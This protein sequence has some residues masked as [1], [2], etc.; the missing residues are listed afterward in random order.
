MKR[1][2]GKVSDDELI[3]LVKKCRLPDTTIAGIMGYSTGTIATRRRALLG[4]KTSYESNTVGSQWDK[5]LKFPSKEKE[6]AIMKG[7]D[8]SRW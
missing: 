4:I 1:W 6:A 2:N 7:V 5:P 3:Y 8:Y